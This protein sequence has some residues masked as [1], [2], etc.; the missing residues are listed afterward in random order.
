MMSRTLWVGSLLLALAPCRA[1][2]GMTEDECHALKLR[3]AGGLQACRASRSA[4]AILQGTSEPR[5]CESSFRTALA[6]IDRRAAKLGVPCRFRDLGA[7]S[8]LDLDTGLRWEKKANLDGIH[9]FAN[10][11]D[12]DNDYSWTYEV[13]ADPEDEGRSPAPSGTAFT[14]FLARLNDCVTDWNEVTVLS[15]GFAGHCDWR[16]PTL[17]ELVGLVDRTVVGCGTGA[18]CIDERF[19]PTP[20]SM[21][22]SLS[23][24]PVDTN[25][26]EVSFATGIPYVDDEDSKRGNRSVRAVRGGW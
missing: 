13:L 19:G 8:V 2:G 22:W 21:Y 1:A 18:P 14:D 25:A 9:D 5:P 11:H 24:G 20:A 7:G 16:L 4:Q 15:A 10:P 3:A 26:W 6:R 17:D 12:A 23:S